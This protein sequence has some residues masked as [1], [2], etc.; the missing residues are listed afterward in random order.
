MAN[1]CRASPR[2]GSIRISVQPGEGGI[3]LSVRNTGTIDATLLARL[4]EPF[5][6]TR[7]DGT[8][9]GLL[10]VQRIVAAH[11]GR[12]RISSEDGATTASAWFP[13]HAVHTERR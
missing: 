11:G 10:L 4:P 8:G 5:L 7:R 1:A 6:T 13:S 12:L 2:G 3:S 9:L